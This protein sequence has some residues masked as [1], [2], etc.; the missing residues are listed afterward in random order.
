MADVDAV[1]MPV[2]ASTA[3]RG[4]SSTGSSYFNRPWT[5]SGFPAMSLPT[6]LDTNG[7][8]FGM[9]IAA[10]PYAEQRLLDV[11]AWCEHVLG[12]SAAPAGV[13]HG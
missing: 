10:Q 12:F 13:I 5:V 9:Q 11:A 6:G 4:L 2:A 1:F 3:P 8:P 7:L